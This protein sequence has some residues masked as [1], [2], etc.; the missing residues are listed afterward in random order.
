VKIDFECSLHLESLTGVYAV[1]AGGGT[2]GIT[3]SEESLDKFIGLSGLSSFTKC[4][5]GGWKLDI[6]KCCDT[7][8]VDAAMKDALSPNA[9]YCPRGSNQSWPSSSW[10]LS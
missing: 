10:K 6:Y 3:P 1:G 9:L 7:R 2:L 8:S 5:T 4:N